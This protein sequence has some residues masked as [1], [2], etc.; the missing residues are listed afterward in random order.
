MTA[1]RACRLLVVSGLPGTGKTTLAKKLVRELQAVYLRVDVVETPLTRV[2]IDVGPLGYEIVSEL[3]AS[4]L[5]MGL[6][7]LVDLVNPLPITRRIWTD[8]STELGVG[9]VVFE[10]QVPDADEHRRR[11]EARLPDLPGQVLPT[12][13]DVLA[14]EYVPWDEDRDGP[15]VLVDMTDSEAGVRLALEA[16]ALKALR[17]ELGGVPFQRVK[18]SVRSTLW[19]RW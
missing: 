2:G 7:V 14:R 5:G 4:N 16:M 6:S 12:W 11:V 15:R 18:R 1:G 8:M 9:L 3:A 10:C 13:P 19:P 17:A